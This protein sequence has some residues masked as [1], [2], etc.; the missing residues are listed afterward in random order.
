MKETP[1]YLQ[2]LFLLPEPIRKRVELWLSDAVDEKSRRQVL[3][4]IENTP[5]RLVDLFGSDFSFGTAG[6]RALMDV[7]TSRLNSYTVAKAAAGVAKYFKGQNET[8]PVVIAYDSRHNSLS[9]AKTVAQVLAGS[10]IK[11]YVCKEIRPSPFLSFL[12]LYKKCSAGIMITASHN[13]KEYNGFE[14]YG[15]DGGGITPS[16]EEEIV[17]EARTIENY[18]Q[19]HYAGQ[20]DPLIQWLDLEELDKAYLKAISLLQQNP[21]EDKLYGPSL[22]IVYTSLHG[23]GITL[24]PKALAAWGFTT[25]S[26]VE[27]QVT[28]DGDFPTLIHPNPGNPDS[29]TL[30]VKQM[31]ETGSDLLI[32]NDCDADRIGVAVIHKGKSRILTGNEFATLCAY[33][34]GKGQALHP[35]PKGAFVIS[36]VTTELIKDIAHSYG[37]TCFEVPTGFKYISEKIHL[38][39]KDPQGYTFLLGAEESCGCLL[40]TYTRNKDGIAGAGVIAEIAL[41]AKRSGKTLV[42]MLYDIYRKYGVSREKLY[43]KVFPES[44]KGFIER[45]N[46]MQRLRDT[47]PLIIKGRKVVSKEDFLSGIKDDFLLGTHENKSLP[48]SDMLLFRLEDGSKAIIRPSGTEPT[49]RIHVAARLKGN[50]DI[51]EL[52]AEG[53]SKV[54]ELLEAWVEELS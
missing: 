2:V 8:G 33:H 31:E 35:T 44:E 24:T 23:A 42:D 26:L 30:G 25:L 43:S 13:P 27:S 22:P 50:A 49:L 6:F 7:G 38:W 3:S 40:G 20:N 10:G 4:I 11:V 36:Y 5:E 39:E 21:A 12:V 53:E 9:F 18:N 15:P 54:T 32:A 51:E 28:L 16:L 48:Y 17:K 45:R 41:E 37:V 14:L 1:S 47:P 34:V 19:I 46:L 52:I 29:L